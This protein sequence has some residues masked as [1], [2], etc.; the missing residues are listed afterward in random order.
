MSFF[1]AAAVALVATTANFQP[2]KERKKK[3]KEYFESIIFISKGFSLLHFRNLTSSAT[4]MLSCAATL[5]F[6][7]KSAQN[8]NFSLKFYKIWA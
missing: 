7:R 6:C 3:R 1:A 5:H 2:K 8:L 4:K